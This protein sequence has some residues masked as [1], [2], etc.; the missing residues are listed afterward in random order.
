MA[1]PPRRKRYCVGNLRSVTNRGK[2]ASRLPRIIWTATAASIS[3]G[4]D[5]PIGAVART[6]RN[7]MTTPTETPRKQDNAERRL[8]QGGQEPPKAEGIRWRFPK[9]VR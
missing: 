4:T 9:E 5:D 1:R 2:K 3:P 6:P 7:S 8:R